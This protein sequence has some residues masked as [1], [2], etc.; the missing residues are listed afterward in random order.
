MQLKTLNLTNTLFS[1]VNP[2]PVKEAI[3]QLGFDVGKCR[4]P[5]VDM[6]EEGQIKISESLQ[7]YF[8][9]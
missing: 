6:D 1:E 5:L 2:I 3:R 4:L 7:N 9:D 8:R